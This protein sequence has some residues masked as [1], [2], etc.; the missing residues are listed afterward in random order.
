M[1]IVKRQTKL[2]QI[3]LTLCPASGLSR[4]LYGWKQ[5]SDQNR[6]DCNNDEQFNQREPSTSETRTRN[7]QQC[8]QRA[9]KKTGLR[10]RYPTGHSHPPTL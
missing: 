7:H 4:L 8:L 9:G 1:I 3:V 6:N 2:L 10:K 5:Q